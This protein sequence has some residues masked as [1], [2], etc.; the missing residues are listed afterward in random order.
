MNLTAIQSSE[1][2]RDVLLAMVA[3]GLGGTG[4]RTTTY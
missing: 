3:A 1:K 2:S 4:E